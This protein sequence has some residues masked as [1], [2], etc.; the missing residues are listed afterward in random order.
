MFE[1]LKERYDKGR[2][3][4]AMLRVYVRKGVI[5]R[6]EFVEITGEEY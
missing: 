1:K 2:I 5:T 3:T 4:I 6:E